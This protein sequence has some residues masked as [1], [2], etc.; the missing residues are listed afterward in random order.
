MAKLPLLASLTLFAAAAGA[1]EPFYLG[2][3]TDEGTSQGI[4]RCELD[5]NTGALRD[6]GLAAMA[7][8]PSFLV[9]HPNGRFVYTVNEVGHDGFVTGFARQPDGSLQEINH[10]SSNGDGT[11]HISL[12]REGKHV[13]V[14]S[15]NSGS[16]AALPIREDGSLGPVSGFVQQAGAG[17]NPDRQEGPH[18][19]S[20]YVDSTG[21]RAYECDLGLDR[22]FIY[23]FD[24]EH[25]TLQPDQPPF[26][27]ATP[28]CGPRHLA[29]GPGERFL[30]MAEEMQS[31]IAVLARDPQNGGLKQIQELS[32]ISS[33]FHDDNSTAEVV[34]HPN[35]KFVYISNRGR[36]SIAAF[37]V[38]ADGKLTWASE[39]PTRGQHPRFFTFDP[40]GKFML[41]M[42]M[43]ERNVLTYFVDAETGALKAT[44][45]QFFRDMPVCALFYPAK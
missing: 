39:T 15:Y 29:F 31:G 7:P 2:T 23:R 38:G 33:D 17:P 44:G 40:S 12:D 1:T 22:V 10:Q 43:W 4:Y 6:F 14:A 3:Y 41:V 16:V 27:K 35:G 25:G 24:P 18:A 42:N 30:Y 8:N 11:T 5:E 13:L 21:R 26:F 45:H 36:D 28:G 20:I 9:L 19:H 34:M 32:T 37:A